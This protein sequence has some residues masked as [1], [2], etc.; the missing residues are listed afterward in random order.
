MK[1]APTSPTT[2]SR[3]EVALRIGRSMLDR[4]E[5]QSANGT[6]S[7]YA[8]QCILDLWDD[9]AEDAPSPMTTQ[10]VD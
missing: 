4:V 7:G 5:K 10:G 8:L 9:Q 3:D 6:L 1:P 2:L